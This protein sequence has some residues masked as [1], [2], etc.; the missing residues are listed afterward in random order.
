MVCGFWESGFYAYYTHCGPGWVQIRI[1][2][3]HG[4]TWTRCVSPG[5]TELG[6][7]WNIT[8]AWYERG[9]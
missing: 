2:N 1:V 8:R 7:S 3:R 4:E 6:S 9:C 5:T